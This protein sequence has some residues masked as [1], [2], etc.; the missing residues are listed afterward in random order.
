MLGPES[1]AMLSQLRSIFDVIVNFKSAQE[2]VYEVRLLKGAARACAAPACCGLWHPPTVDTPRD[3]GA[4]E[5][6]P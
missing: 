4:R 6:C 5:I 2:G 1:K 3:L